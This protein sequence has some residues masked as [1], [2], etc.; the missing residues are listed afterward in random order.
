MGKQTKNKFS[1]D[2]TFKG[3]IYPHQ[4]R[5]ICMLRGLHSV[6]MGRSSKLTPS[7]IVNQAGRAGG[8]CGFNMLCIR[9]DK[10][11]LNRLS[12]ISF[13]EICSRTE[14]YLSFLAEVQIFCSD[15][16][17]P[18]RNVS[19]DRSRRHTSTPFIF[20]QCPSRPCQNVLLVQE[21]FAM[22]EYSTGVWIS[23]Y[24]SSWGKKFAVQ[25]VQQDV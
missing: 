9:Y 13:I 15:S 16:A 20:L 7:R 18:P 17:A 21:L 2:E 8:L 12:Q 24:T 11:T 22:Y 5:Y 23:T 6:A 4:K 14:L 25:V 1:L 19:F 3:P 10:A